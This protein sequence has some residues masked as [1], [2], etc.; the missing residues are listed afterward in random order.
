VL[1]YPKKCLPFR[2][3]ADLDKYLGAYDSKQITVKIIFTKQSDN[4]LA[5]QTGQEKITLKPTGKD[6]FSFEQAGVV[7]EF[8]IA[9]SEMTLKQ[10]GGTFLFTKEK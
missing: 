8:D 2:V 3:A 6:S 9:K 5:E 7:I 10:G 1:L 4:L